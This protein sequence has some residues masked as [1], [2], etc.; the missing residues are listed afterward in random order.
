V[1]SQVIPLGNPL[2]VTMGMG[3]LNNNQP[4]LVQLGIIEY[5]QIIEAIRDAIRG[6]GASPVIDEDF[7]YYKIAAL[8]AEVNKS[9]LE[10]P[11][12][13]KITRLVFEKKIKI[14]VGLTEQNTRKSDPYRI[15]IGE[16]KVIRGTDE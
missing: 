12:Y 15:V 11:L 2:I 14:K 9:P 6:D 13:N 8:L 5:F 4:A 7:D 10:N 1:A 3:Q 16:Y